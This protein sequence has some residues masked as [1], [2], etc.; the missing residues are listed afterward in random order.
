MW[1]S[2]TT[3]QTSFY[4]TFSLYASLNHLASHSLHPPWYQ[5]F[6]AQDKEFFFALIVQHENTK[7]NNEIFTCGKILIFPSWA[8]SNH[9][10]GNNKTCKESDETS[11]SF[12]NLG[13]LITTESTPELTAE[14]KKLTISLHES[15]KE[16]KSRCIRTQ[17]REKKKRKKKLHI[18]ISTKQ[19]SNHIEKLGKSFKSYFSSNLQ[20][21]VWKSQWIKYSYNIDK[22]TVQSYWKVGEIIQIIFLCN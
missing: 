4:T 1:K 17:N 3:S 2:N 14:R 21:R 9:L 11:V 8:Q 16:Y 12:R 22:T 18:T 6:I 5:P 20:G 19:Q 15:I 7:T 13:M 10:I